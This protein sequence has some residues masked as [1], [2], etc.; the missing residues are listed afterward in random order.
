MISLKCYSNM[1]V[2]M[3]DYLGLINSFR[4][5]KASYVISFFISI[6]KLLLTSYETSDVTPP[7]FSLTN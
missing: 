6:R 5:F 3:M 1:N 7:N 4:G 2:L